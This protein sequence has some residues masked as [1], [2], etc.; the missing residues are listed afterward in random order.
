MG[1]KSACRPHIK[2][3]KKPGV[4]V[5]LGLSVYCEYWIIFSSI[6]NISIFPVKTQYDSSTGIGLINFLIVRP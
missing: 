5:P 1:D 4:F 6:S 3:N 2:K